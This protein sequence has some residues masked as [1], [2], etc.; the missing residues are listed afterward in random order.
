[1]IEKLQEVLRGALAEAKTAPDIFVQVI[2]ELVVFNSMSI[3]EQERFANALITKWVL[4]GRRGRKLPPRPKKGRRKRK[5]S[6]PSHQKTKAAIAKLLE[7]SSLSE[8][9][10]HGNTET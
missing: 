2:D 4:S 5:Q 7:G 9:E 8:G 10:L 6:K 3:E 1:M